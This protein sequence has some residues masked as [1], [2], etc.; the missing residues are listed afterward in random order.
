MMEIYW[1]DGLLQSLRLDASGRVQIECDLYLNEESS[2]RV[3]FL[4]DCSGVSSFVAT[5]DCNAIIESA[6]AGNINS[7]RFEQRPRKARIKLFL[8]DGYVDLTASAIRCEQA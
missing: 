3:R 2:R 4:F 6:R 1:H 7:G 8:N 5:I